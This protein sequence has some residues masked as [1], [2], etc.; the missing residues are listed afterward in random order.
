MHP[1]TNHYNTPVQCTYLSHHKVPRECDC[2]P[3]FSSGVILVYRVLKEI[4]GMFFSL[5]PEHR[6][7]NYGSDLE[8]CNDDNEKAIGSQEDAR[9][10]DGTTV[11]QE[12]DNEDKCTGGDENVSTL[13]NHG[14][15]CHL[16]MWM[17]IRFITNY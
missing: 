3:L 15:L 1:L 14:W 10:L 2:I 12:T 8:E 6:G 7:Q 17:Q 5:F 16:L 9:F 11:A 4:L 13:L